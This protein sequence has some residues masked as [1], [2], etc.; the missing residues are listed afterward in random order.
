[1]NLS[2]ITENPLSIRFDHAFD[3][4]SK[5]KTQTIAKNDSKDSSDHFTTAPRVIAA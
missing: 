2:F 5:E 4:V 3:G 1:M